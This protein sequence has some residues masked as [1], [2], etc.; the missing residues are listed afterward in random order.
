MLVYLPCDCTGLKSLLN[1][2]G[3]WKVVRASGEEDSSEQSEEVVAVC[4][5]VCIRYLAVMW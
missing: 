4:V 2:N 5:S 1:W 3:S